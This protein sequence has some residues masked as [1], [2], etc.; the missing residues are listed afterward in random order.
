[1]LDRLLVTMPEW[2]ER[3]IPDIGI[4]LVELMAYVA[5]QLSY[6]LDAVTT[7]AYLSTARL[8]ISVRRHARLVDYRMHEGCNARSWVC[9]ESDTNQIFEITDLAFG[10]PPTAL[11]DD[12]RA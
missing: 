9:I 12:F 4:T 11:W 10:V 2:R 1:M 8:R 3:H 6:S 5:D 7:E